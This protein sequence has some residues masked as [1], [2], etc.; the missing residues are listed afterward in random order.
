MPDHEH[1]LRIVS[2]LG[3]DDLMAEMDDVSG[4]VYPLESPSV[5]LARWLDGGTSRTV[6][7]A[8][9][10]SGQWVVTLRDGGTTYAGFDV[11]RSAALA[12]ALD[13]AEAVKR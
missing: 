13:Q 3:L 1:Y 10:R 5:R 12:A 8:C 6:T 2:A 9:S 11:V 4:E 7:I